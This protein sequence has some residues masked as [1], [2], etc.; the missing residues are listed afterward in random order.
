MISIVV[1]LLLMAL[2]VVGYTYTD[3]A[4]V[5]ALIPAL[6]GV[7]LVG[8]GVLARREN[9]RKHAMHLAM[10]LALVGM[11]ASG[12]RAAL[13]MTKQMSGGEQGN[14]PAAPYINLFIALTCAV[15]IILGIKS[16]VDARRRREQKAS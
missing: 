3:R 4:S 12:W 9:L 7:I 11:V 14:Y 13:G 15:F 16:F 10:L 2:G 1:G 8:L 5:T 6:L